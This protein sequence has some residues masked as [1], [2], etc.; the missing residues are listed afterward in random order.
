MEYN[1]K[2]WGRLPDGTMC[3]LIKISHNGISLFV[4]DY[5]ATFQSLFTTDSDGRRR[6]IIL[7]Y[8]TPEEYY[9]DQQN[10]GGTMGR[11]ANRIA[12]ACITLNGKD[13]HLTANEGCNTLHSGRGFNKCMWKYNVCSD[14]LTLTL[15][16]PHL[17]NGFPGNLAVTQT[18][19]IT[20]NHSV[21]IHYDAVSDM[22]TVCNFTNHSYFNFS[23]VKNICDYIVSIGADCYTPVDNHSIPT[24]DILSVEGTMYDF[25]KPRKV[26]TDYIDINYVLSDS[27][28][29]AAKVTDSE[30][31]ITMYVKTDFPG[32]QLYNGNYIG[33]CTGKYG[34]QYNDQHGI[35]FEPQ[36]FPDAMHHDNFPSP[37][38][39]TGEHLDRYIEYIF[40]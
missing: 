6:D 37:V 27:Y 15:N 17:D 29:Y 28:E 11:F 7:G 20:D 13:W 14:S 26:G 25:R 1:I 39:K 9:Y 21:K 24:G 4:S 5:G 23:G 32:L 8:D 40:E 36:F 2:E 12:G 31:G 33:R 30:T 34:I 35:C 19:T 18:I 16:S 3:H 10:F 22:D 38:L